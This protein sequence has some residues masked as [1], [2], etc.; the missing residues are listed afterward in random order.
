MA[1]REDI[2]EVEENGVAIEEKVT[3]QD[4]ALKDDAPVAG[5][6]ADYMSR[7][8]E[9]PDGTKTYQLL[10]PFKQRFRKAGSRDEYERTIE[11]LTF[12]RM[13]GGDLKATASFTN[14]ELRGI[15]LFLRLSRLSE[16]EFE[17]LDQDDLDA[18]FKVMGSFLPRTQKT[19]KT[20]SP[21]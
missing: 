16:A 4:I 2:V 1:P 12:R 7:V 21:Q 6:P 10:H 14:D 15:Q 3:A 20:A 13:N 19:G 9:N 18:A 5:D 11:S 17:K 8:T